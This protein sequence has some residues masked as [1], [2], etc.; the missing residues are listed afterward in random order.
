MYYI[1]IYV[2]LRCNSTWV[3]NYSLITKPFAAGFRRNW[4]LEL[5]V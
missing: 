5:S 2:I 4:I 1:Y 3:S